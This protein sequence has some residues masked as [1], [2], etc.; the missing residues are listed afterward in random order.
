MGGERI[1][2]KPFYDQAGL[3]YFYKPSEGPLHKGS[4]N[5]LFSLS[6][7]YFIDSSG[8][9]AN[10]IRGF[11]ESLR[12]EV[13]KRKTPIYIF[14]EHNMAYYCWV[15]AFNENRITQGATVLHFDSHEDNGAD[16]D[17]EIPSLNDLAATAKLAQEKLNVADFMAPAFRNGLVNKM[18]W[19]DPSCPG[20]YRYLPSDSTSIPMVYF[21]PDSWV[22]DKLLK[23]IT[24]RRQLILDIDLDYFMWHFGWLDGDYYYQRRTSFQNNQ[25]VFEHDILKIKKAIAKA[26]VVT[27]AASP[28]FISEAG[29][30]IETAIKI[31]K[32]I[33]DKQGENIIVGSN[34]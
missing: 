27:I 9:I 17:Q 12:V 32:K 2:H 19:I 5:D 28:E 13:G 21:S 30:S 23:S 15:E 4:I 10:Y 20:D 31:V 6:T 22:Y 24:N 25:A 11:S 1:T 3:S 14:N 16:W 8:T 7:P 29:I 34:S 33:I 18:V 26:G